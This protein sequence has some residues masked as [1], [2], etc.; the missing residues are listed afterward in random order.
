MLTRGSKTVAEKVVRESE[1]GPDMGSPDR[2]EPIPPVTDMQDSPLFKFLCEL[3]PIQP[4][5][6][7]HHAQTYNELSFPQE[8]RVFASPR[9]ATRRSSTSSLKRCVAA[10]RLSAQA[11]AE[12]RESLGWHQGGTMSRSTVCGSPSP[13]NRRSDDHQVTPYSRRQSEE[14]GA[15]QC[16]DVKIEASGD[17]VYM[18]EKPGGQAMSAVNSAEPNPDCTSHEMDGTGGSGGTFETEFDDYSQL[19]AHVSAAMASQMV[20]CSDGKGEQVGGARSEMS[21]GG[22]RRQST[23]SLVSHVIDCVVPGNLSQESR[24]PEGEEQRRMSMGCSSGIEGH[25]LTFSPVAKGSPELDRE[26][27]AMAYFLAGNQELG[28]GSEEWSED[29]SEVVIPRLPL[30]GASGYS[31]KEGDLKNE[32]VRRQEGEM[33]DAITPQSGLGACSEDGQDLGTVIAAQNIGQQHGLLS[34]RGDS[35]GQRGFRRRCLDFDASVARRKSLGSIGGRKAVGSRLKDCSG[36]TV[37]DDSSA[38]CVVGDAVPATPDGNSGKAQGRVDDFINSNDSS[39]VASESGTYTRGVSTCGDS[40]GSMSRMQFTS[41]LYKKNVDVPNAKGEAQTP[42]SQ[43][44]GVAGAVV[45]A[46]G[47]RRSP[48]VRPT[49]IG[50]HLNSLTSAVPYKREYPSSGG[51]T[52]KGVLATVL[53]LQTMACPSPKE[54]PCGEGMDSAGY[55]RGGSQSFNPGVGSLLERRSEMEMNCLD[56]ASVMNNRVNIPAPDFRCLNLESLS[57]LEESLSLTPGASVVSVVSPRGQKRSQGHREESM[58]AAQ[59]QAAGEAMDDILGSP[60]SSKRRRL[61]RRKSTVTTQSDKSGDGC[62][63]CN[64]KKSKCLKLYCE[65]FA[66]GVYCVGSCACR[67]CF[68]K[69][70]YEETVINTRHQIESRNPLAFAPK[71]VQTAESSPVPGDEALDTPASAR[72][73]RG[74]NCKKS[75]CLK[76]YCECYQ[77]G[78]GCSEGCRCEGCKNM[79]G[80]KEGSEGDDKEAEQ[81]NS[82]REEPQAEDPIE[83][84]NRMSGKSD[85]LRDSAKANLSPITPTFENDGHGRPMLRLRSMGRKRGSASD[86]HCGSPLAD[87]ASRPPTSPTRFSQTLD[88]FHLVPYPQG[89]SDFSMSAAG[90]SPMTTP[91]FA[92][93]G[94]VSPRWEGLGDICTLTPLP[95][96]QLRPTPGSSCVTVERPSA[97]PAFSSHMTESPYHAGS[98]TS[99]HQRV[100][101]RHWSPHEDSPS[102]FRQ[103]APRSPLRFDTPR[104][105]QL[106]DQ[107]H[108]TP[109]TPS[110]PQQSPVLIS[111]R[112][113]QSDLESAKLVADDDGTPEFL[114]YADESFGSPSRSTV[115]KSNSPKQKRVTPPRYGGYREPASSRGG[116]GSIPQSSL[117]RR[118]ILQALPTPPSGAPSYPN[119]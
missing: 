62:K 30:Q 28:H 42:T 97:S 21:D 58:S 91:T 1:S 71:I 51:E 2:R 119:G 90:E 7:V 19:G 47:L 59:V 110:M 43:N 64:C 3:S 105:S 68:N 73:K 78:V 25:G 53:G 115:T 72:H 4:A 5:K 117:A 50:L 32:T 70:E 16:M 99:V 61:S 17:D 26:T 13:L 102:R 89:D 60:Q 49:G 74:C 44:S 111:G 69:P 11:Q 116:G 112:N 45:P 88:G 9:S 113:L 12:G 82:G 79:Y 56:G 118:F 27:T 38:G 35:S 101:A 24:C 18:G 100:A 93:I 48:R 104:Q 31:G 66:A 29:S 95:L 86:E 33:R 39:R 37:A 103:P 14:A 87:P 36:S 84:L 94:H 77:A 41:G 98:S 65:C 57:A 46:S 76:K 96:A 55:G 40:L 109:P 54:N 15:S 106:S 67:D 10:E 75:L 83:L 108:S 34:N 52:S 22:E 107:C 92:R 80:R 85:R 114:K 81:V 23:S 63:R 8:H 6:S 20:R